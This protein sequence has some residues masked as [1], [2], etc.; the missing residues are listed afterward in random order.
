MIRPTLPILALLALPLAAQAP[1][2]PPPGGE[3]MKPS[4]SG[5][6]QGGRRAPGGMMPGGPEQALMALGLTP[7]QDRAVKAILD[8]GRE[9]DRPVH[10]LVMDKEEA[11]RAAAEDPATPEAHLKALHAGASEARYRLLLAHRER[12]R[13]IHALLSAEQKAKLK[14]V[15]EKM[16]RAREARRALMEEMP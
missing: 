5:P 9:A 16:A 14:R 3:A 13:E 4:P 11:L 7:D 10:K 2:F 15:Q 6:E 12:L 8:K 1:A